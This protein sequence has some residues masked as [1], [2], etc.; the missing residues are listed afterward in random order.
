MWRNVFYGVIACLSVV[1]LVTLVWYVTRLPLFTITAVRVVGGETVQGEVVQGKVELILKESYLRIIPHRFT[2]LYPHDRIVETLR[3]IHRLKDITVERVGRNELLVSYTEYVPYALWCLYGEE[4][5]CY[6]IDA[7]GYAYEEAP[8]LDGGSLVRHIF[9][10][11]VA[12]ERG[13]NIPYDSFVAS[14]AFI[15][16]LLTSF[17][18]RVTHV[19]YSNESDVTLTVHG[20]GKI[21][22]S[23][24]YAVADVLENLGT[25]L[26]SEAFAH[27][28][29]GNFN[30]IDLRFGNK[31]FVNEEISSEF[32]AT[33]S[34]TTVS[35]GSE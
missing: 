18:L 22:M 33:S 32:E 30:Y 24:K 19:E 28:E 1:L 7:S 11:D 12:P 25:I 9:Q 2:Y 27:L 6:F 8:A 23:Q 3:T 31:I 16:A 5:P 21:L 15:E 17:S 4:R 35:S 34:T 20:G 13:M 10:K 26:S 14:H 29:P